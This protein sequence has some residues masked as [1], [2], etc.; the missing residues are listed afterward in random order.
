MDEETLLSGCSPSIM[1]DQSEPFN[2]RPG[3]EN[4]LCDMNAPVDEC[5]NDIK[6]R[7]SFLHT[8]R[9]V[10]EEHPWVDS[11]FANETMQTKENNHM[12]VQG[13]AKC[14]IEEKMTE[15]E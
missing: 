11:H 8:S 13:I 4:R 14:S 7:W 6:G 10:A 3:K 5:P 1:K 12:I 15:N 9:S 2:G